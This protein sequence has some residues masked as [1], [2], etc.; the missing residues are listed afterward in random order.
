MALTVVEARNAKAGER[1]YKLA[2]SAGLYL[3]VTKKGAKSW[4]YKY[5]YAGKEKRLT[6]GLFPD[7]SL[8]EA[9]DRRDEAKAMLR[10]GK[11][12][13]VEAEKAKH[14]QIAAAGATFKAIAEEWMADE[15]PRWSEAH[16]TR[17]RFR[18]ENDIYPAL[19]RMPIADITGPMVLRE[20]RKIEKRGS[21]ETAKR[22]K[23]YIS[24]IF[25]RAEGEHYIGGDSVL[26]IS[27]LSKALKPTPVGS[28]QPALTTVPELLELQMAVERST[29]DLKTKIA[30]RLLALTV[31]RVGVL[32]QA[33]WDEFDGIDWS[34]PDAPSPGA[35][36]RIS[37]SRMKLEVE[38]KGNEAFG[39]EVPLPMQAVALLRVLHV[40][41]GK[42][43]LLFPG[44]KSWR[45]AMSDAALSTLYKRMAGGKYK[46][47]MVP[48]GWR[49]AFSTIMNERA[50]AQRSDG[51][52]MII[53][54]MLA[55]VPKGMSASEWAYNRAR[56]LEPRRELGQAWADI[57]TEGLP[58][59]AL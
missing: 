56:Y 51:D 59:P 38:D 25:E 45:E 9:R 52:R 13:I 8:S 16:R 14:A 32:R 49:S 4:R 58:A 55:H 41:T 40:M 17:V 53:D 50:A 21:I 19:G 23:G 10:A 30:S 20:L 6:F 15:S 33:T 28:K 57:I 27:R 24:A 7:V 5:R 47:R 11:D 46:G 22:V 35:L 18:L 36:W 31:V 34:K 29:S 26:A 1:D 43:Q 42:Y 44:G 2:D 39:H 37:A 3:F 12:P 48:H 54:M